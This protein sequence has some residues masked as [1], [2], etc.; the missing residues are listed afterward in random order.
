MDA[1]F[2]TLV[3]DT[4]FSAGGCGAVFYTHET[5]TP[6]HPMAHV[7]RSNSVVDLASW[8]PCGT[9]GSPHTARDKAR[10]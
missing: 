10:I 7:I 5:M 6:G 2:L 1:I 8:M 9:V 4:L 3:P